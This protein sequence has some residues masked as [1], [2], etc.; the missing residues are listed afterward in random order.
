MIPFPM[1]LNHTRRGSVSVFEP[2]PSDNA[3]LVVSSCNA[4]EA[5]IKTESSGNAGF[6]SVISRGM[7]EV[8]SL[9]CSEISP[10]AQRYRKDLLSL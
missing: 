3:D 5:A 8:R 7:T 6:S 10:N 2:D 4:S 9:R 1:T